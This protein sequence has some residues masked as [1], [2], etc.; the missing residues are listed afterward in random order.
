MKKKSIRRVRWASKLAVVVAAA[1]LFQFS[2]CITFNS[3]V[4]QS[5][6]NSLPS[7]YFSTIQSFFLLPIRTLLSGGFETIPT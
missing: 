6:I 3:Q 2:Q 4:A 1:P 7:L 5:V